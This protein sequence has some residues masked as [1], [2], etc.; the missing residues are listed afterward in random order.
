[1]WDSS[2][3]ADDPN[4][5]EHSEAA[6]DGGDYNSACCVPCKARPPR[7]GRP[8]LYVANGRAVVQLPLCLALLVYSIGRDWGNDLRRHPVVGG[9]ARQ[10]K[11]H[12]PAAAQAHVVPRL[13][14][15]HE[16]S[17]QDQ[18]LRILWNWSP[19]SPSCVVHAAVAPR[20]QA[21]VVETVGDGPEMQ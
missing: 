21:V 13:R 5:L 9:V 4:W 8:I 20:G 15:D 17:L 18:L 12:V 14:I 2:A 6:I 11:R 7:R 1:M 10:L 16:G 3:N 19:A